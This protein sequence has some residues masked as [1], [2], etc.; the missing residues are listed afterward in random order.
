M[1][2]F[3]VMIYASYAISSMAWLASKNTK[4]EYRIIF[5]SYCSLPPCMLVVR[6]CLVR[7]G[8]VSFHHLLRQN[9]HAKS[10]R[11]LL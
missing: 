2:T 3:L 11:S 8:F 5:A 9:A 7:L 10:A 6:P 1:A 4:Y